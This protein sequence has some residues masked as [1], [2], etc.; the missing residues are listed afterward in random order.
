MLPAEQFNTLYRSSQQAATECAEVV[1]DGTEQLLKLQMDATQQV[2]AKG[3]EQLRE[4]WSQ[5]DPVPGAPDALGV[6]E[7]GVRRSVEMTRAY[8]TTVTRLQREFAHIIEWQ[9]PVL[10]E[11]WREVMRGS[12]MAGAGGQSSASGSCES[13]DRRSR[14]AA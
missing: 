9:A 10:G 4:L 7:D 3:G 1:L 5:V 2:L 14:K 12:L 11:K 13:A 6:V 8:L